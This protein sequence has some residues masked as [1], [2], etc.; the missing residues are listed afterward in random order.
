MSKKSPK[1]THNCRMILG[2]SIIIMYWWTS[3][4]KKRARIVRVEPRYRSN[5]K[6]ICLSSGV[7]HR[8]SIL[9]IQQYSHTDTLCVFTQSKTHRRI[10]QHLRTA[11]EC[12][13]MAC[14]MIRQ[15]TIRVLRQRNVLVLFRQALRP[16]SSVGHAA[17]RNLEYFCTNAAVRDAL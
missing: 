6:T 4:E 13:K 8:S 10:K 7:C 12:F 14:G 1:N 2:V 3:E 15:H 17:V 9:C 11:Q 5:E 16:V